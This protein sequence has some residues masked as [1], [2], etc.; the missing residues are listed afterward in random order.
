MKQRLVLIDL[1]TC[2]HKPYKAI[3]DYH[4]ITDLLVVPGLVTA[5][6][7]S[8]QKDT[9]GGYWQDPAWW[10]LDIEKYPKVWASLSRRRTRDYGYIKEDQLTRE[11][12]ITALNDCPLL[13]SR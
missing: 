9:T 11:E 8:L 13:K 5:I 6:R 4:L 1:F 3:Y 7:N 12:I 2:E 10:I